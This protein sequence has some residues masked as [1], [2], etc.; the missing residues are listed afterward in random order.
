DQYPDPASVTGQS[1]KTGQSELTVLKPEWQEHF[2]QVILIIIKF[3]KKAVSQPGTEQ[4][5]HKYV[6][7]QLVQEFLGLIFPPEHLEHDNV[8]DQKCQHKTKGIIMQ[9]IPQYGKENRIGVPE[10]SGQKTHYSVFFKDL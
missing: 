2:Q 8:T 6:D 9:L 7:A 4:R 5:T 1:V 3:I 10:N